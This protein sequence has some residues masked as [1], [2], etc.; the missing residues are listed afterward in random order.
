[1]SHYHDWRY[2]VMS[3]VTVV[4]LSLLVVVACKRVTDEDLWNKGVEAQKADKF[5]ESLLQYDQLVKDYPQSPKVPDAL[6]AMASIYQSNKRD[7]PKAIG[8]YRKV[9]QE[10]PNHATA[11]SAS[12][13]IGFLYNNELKNLDSAKA[14]Y[15]LFLKKYPDNPMAASAQFELNNLGKDPNEIID[16]K[17]K[18]LKPFPKTNP[19]KA[20]IKK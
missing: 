11:S 10:Y 20:S 1:M 9:A 12:F 3:R 5:E 16:I 15:E 13:L 18:P 19:K 14:A 6:Y 2:R 8:L 7:I 17:A 4:L